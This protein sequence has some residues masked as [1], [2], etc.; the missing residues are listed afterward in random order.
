M[1]GSILALSLTIAAGSVF[2]PIFS[3]SAVYAAESQVNWQRI[4]HRHMS[5]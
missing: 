3:T 2:T 5:A 4:L 1:K